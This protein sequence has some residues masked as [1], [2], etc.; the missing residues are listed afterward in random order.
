M[1]FVMLWMLCVKGMFGSVGVCL[2]ATGM[3]MAM[4]VMSMFA[5]N[6]LVTVMPFAMMD[7]FWSIGT[8]R[9]SRMWATGIG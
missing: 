2:L 6:M 9:S 1:V 3:M 7:I 5:V 8:R 4:M